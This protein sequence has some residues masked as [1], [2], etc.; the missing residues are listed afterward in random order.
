MKF[1]FISTE[2]VINADRIVSV[3]DVIDEAV[4]RQ[5]VAT[6]PAE[7]L[8]D[9]SGEDRPRTAIYLH[10]GKVILSPLNTDKILEQ[11]TQDLE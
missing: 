11:M 3:T 4:C 5:I 10:E 7:D 8:V 6:T 2:S 9:V 1:I